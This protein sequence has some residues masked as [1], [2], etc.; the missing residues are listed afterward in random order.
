MAVV[1]GRNERD[2]TG[3]NK[4][5]FRWHFSITESTTWQQRELHCACY[6]RSWYALS[7]RKAFDRFS[8]LGFGLVLAARHR[9]DVAPE[10]FVFGGR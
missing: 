10:L 1:A 3:R 5:T 9:W 4:R 7:L 2:W 8:S 6:A